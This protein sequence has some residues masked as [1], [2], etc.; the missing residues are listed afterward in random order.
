MKMVRPGARGSRTIY[1][2]RT[3]RGQIAKTLLAERAVVLPPAA[4]TSAPAWK[5][6]TTTITA[7]ISTSRTPGTQSEARLLALTPPTTP[8]RTAPAAGQAT[9]PARLE[10]S[11][12]CWWEP[13][14]RGIRADAG[15]MIAAYPDAAIISARSTPP[16]VSAATTLLR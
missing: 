1:P 12:A 2:A 6:S 5:P 16:T 13:R 10:T 3:G 15:K 7:G 11:T 4:S 9:S 8:Y 14:C